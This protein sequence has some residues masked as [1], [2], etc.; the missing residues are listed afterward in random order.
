MMCRFSH[1]TIV[2]F[3]LG[4]WALKEEL[5][6]ALEDI[7]GIEVT[8]HPEE[9]LPKEAYNSARGQYVGDVFLA[10][11]FALRRDEKEILLGVTAEDLYA[12]GLNFI[13]GLASPSGICVIGLK[14]LDNHFY[15]LPADDTLYF[16]RVL[17]EAVHE[18]GHV[19][20]LAHCP[21][22][23]CV[24]HFSNSLADTDKKGYRFR[25]SCAR[26]ADAV[27]CKR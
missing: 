23:H 19:L 26:K 21:D 1:I 12:S 14:R 13:F 7:F 17:P 4:E 2:P 5:E 9:P 11:L 20:G 18:I 8:W 25:P 27:L 3:A 22:P 16:K 6:I 10:K 15:G 24:M